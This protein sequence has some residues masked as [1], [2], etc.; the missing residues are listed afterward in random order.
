MAG[1]GRSATSRAPITL[2]GTSALGPT[3]SCAIAQGP[4]GAG[5]DEPLPSPLAAC[6]AAWLTSGTRTTKTVLVKAK[7]KR[8]NVKGTG[9]KAGAA[10]HVGGIAPV[11]RLLN[12]LLSWSLV[13]A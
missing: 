11:R 4:P 6:I 3:A 1:Q 10:A 2:T 8:R 7:S 12:R 13:G 5:P 9:R